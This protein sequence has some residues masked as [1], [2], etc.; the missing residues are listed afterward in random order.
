MIWD[1]IAV[2]LPFFLS[3]FFKNSDHLLQKLFDFRETMTPSACTLPECKD[4]F[5]VTRIKLFFPFSHIVR[6]FSI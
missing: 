5:S 1:V 4:Y 6:L 2:C 3:T